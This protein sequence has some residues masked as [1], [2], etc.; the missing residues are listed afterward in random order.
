MC[1][2]INMYIVHYF[3]KKKK[4]MD[5]YCGAHR[6]AQNTPSSL[7]INGKW[8]CV[9]QYLRGVASEIRIVLFELTCTLDLHVHKLNGI[10]CSNS[11]LS[12]THTMITMKVHYATCFLQNG[13]NPVWNISSKNTFLWTFDLHKQRPLVNMSVDKLVK[14]LIWICNSVWFLPVSLSTHGTSCFSETRK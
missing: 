8:K 12:N 7:M 9:Q 5:I 4:N 10:E 13:L 11:W 3:K 2:I 1:N 14:P 6:M